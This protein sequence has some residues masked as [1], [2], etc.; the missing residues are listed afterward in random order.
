MDIRAHEK[1]S[2]EIPSYLKDD[3]ILYY[4]QRIG[5]STYKASKLMLNCISPSSKRPMKMRAV[6][7]RV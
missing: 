7:L 5:I 2:E 6:K 3:C 4:K 1:K